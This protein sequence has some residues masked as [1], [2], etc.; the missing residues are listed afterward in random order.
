MPDPTKGGQDFQPLYRYLQEKMDVNLNVN[1]AAAAVSVPVNVVTMPDII[2]IT[3]PPGEDPLPVTIMSSPGSESANKRL[4]KGMITETQDVIYT[5][6]ALMTTTV[7]QIV[8]SN[9]ESVTVW[10]SLWFADVT[11]CYQHPITAYNSLVIPGLCH[12]LEAGETIE[13]KCELSTHVHY[14]I[15]G[16]EVE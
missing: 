9:Y 16:V 3:V 12:V 14:Y 4:C 8:I 2:N 5:V 10:F 13:A 11:F 6:P 15:S 1:V 7:K